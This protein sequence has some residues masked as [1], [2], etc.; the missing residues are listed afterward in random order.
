MC[1]AKATSCV[2]G[3]SVSDAQLN[4][5]LHAMHHLFLAMQDVNCALM[6][7][8]AHLHGLQ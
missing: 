8:T 1:A 2:I 3:V 6:R 4:T 7:L 5:P